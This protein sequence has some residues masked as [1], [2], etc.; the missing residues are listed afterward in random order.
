MQ[1]ILRVEDLARYIHK[2]ES[3]IRSDVKRNPKS[4]P[5][6]CRLPGTRRLLWRREDVEAWLLQ[7]VDTPEG[8]VIPLTLTDQKKRGRPTKKDQIDKLRNIKN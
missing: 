2:S 4:L 7:F 5:P 8:S 3:T 1:E 6:I